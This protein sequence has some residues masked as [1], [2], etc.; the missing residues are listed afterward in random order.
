MVYHHSTTLHSVYA[1][2]NSSESVVERYRFDAYGKVTVLDPD[3]SADSDNASDVSNPYL[4]QGRR[5]DNKS[6]LYYFRARMM[7]EHLGRFWQRDWC[8]ANK[9]DQTLEAY[10]FADDNPVNRFD[11]SGCYDWWPP[12]E[13]WP[14][15]DDDGC[16]RT[17]VTI[18]WDLTMKC[19]ELS[20]AIPS[21]NMCCEW[22]RN[23]YSKKKKYSYDDCPGDCRCVTDTD[24]IEKTTTET[25]LRDWEAREREGKHGGK[26]KGGVIFHI[27]IRGRRHDECIM[28][29]IKIIEKKTVRKMEGKCVSAK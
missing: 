27:P 10:P 15:G 22:W 23:F 24:E 6:G 25:V 17:M 1:L 13:W 3:H 16:T 29:K 11:P 19:E 14:W 9:D 21:R 8:S 18:A 2:T 20:D 28:R 4:F 7:D 26:W 5:W 12:S